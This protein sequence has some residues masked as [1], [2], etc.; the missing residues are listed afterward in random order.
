MKDEET[1]CS[2][3]IS[4]SHLSTCLGSMQ[5]VESTDDDDDSDEEDIVQPSFK[6]AE[7]EVN[8][9]FRIKNTSPIHQTWRD[10]CADTDHE[11]MSG[12]SQ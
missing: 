12:N 10:L 3:V 2:Y 4:I 9:S 11:P 7:Q 1:L 8:Y 5:R 6:V